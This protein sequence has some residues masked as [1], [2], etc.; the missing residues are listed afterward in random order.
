MADTSSCDFDW[1]ALVISEDPPPIKEVMYEFS[2]G[3]N[4]YGRTENSGVFA[5]ED[6]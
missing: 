2:D 5:E 4:F 6:E 1:S 3:K